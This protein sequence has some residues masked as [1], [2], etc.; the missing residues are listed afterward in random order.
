MKTSSVF[1]KL[2]FRILSTSLLPFGCF[3]MVV[4]LFVCNYAYQAEISRLT[5]QVDD[6]CMETKNLINRAITAAEC[7]Q[8][9]PAI[10]TNIDKEFTDVYEIYEFLD[11]SNIYVDSVTEGVENSTFI[12]YFSNK[13]LYESK[14]FHKS[15]NI[16][17]YEQILR[18]LESNSQSFMWNERIFTDENNKK[19]ICFYKKF[20]LESKVVLSC[21]IQL[22]E[23]INEIFV[24]SESEKKNA[25]SEFVSGSINEYFSAGIYV[26]K[27]KLYLQYGFIFLIAF[28]IIFVI[29]LFISFIAF[30][31][32]RKTTNGI[33]DFV[34]KLDTE[35][36]L[37]TG[38]GLSFSPEEE[39]EL[40]TM[41]KTIIN[42]FNK[43]KDIEIKKKN[44]EIELIQ[45]KLN[46]HTMYNSLSAI[47]LKAYEKNEQEIVSLVD[48]LS[49]YYRLVLNK[50]QS[51]TLIENE[52]AILKKYVQVNE[53]SS[54]ANYEFVCNISDELK[55]CRIPHLILLP[56]VENS[57]IHG[58]SG[59]LN[60]GK[61]EIS[62]RRINRVLEIVITDN[63]IGINDDKLKIFNENIESNVGYGIKN[64]YQRLQLIY[65]NDSTIR[66]ENMADSGTKVTITFVCFK[67][68]GTEVI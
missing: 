36:F 6:Y 52:I 47:R 21:S 46:P 11:A 5:K 9:Y 40:V 13:N 54:Y 30:K 37:E 67:E 34:N 59:K 14:Y 50:G 63:G 68:D 20:P 57:L 23:R 35:D 27:S 39:F 25:S 31:V 32:M 22:P 60:G 43:I 10:L 28:L 51:I 4:A 3:V 12:I 1:R 48:I 45:S 64:V 38:N 66:I 24:I 56:F 16:E 8:R 55:R 7:I 19:N 53:L 29:S 49:E 33:T 58:L 65:G 26:N 17:N 42:L 18:N 15:E 44:V 41:K 62:F 61:I 2:L